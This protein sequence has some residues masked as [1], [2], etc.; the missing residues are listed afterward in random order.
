MTEPR[1]TVA[2]IIMLKTIEAVLDKDGRLSLLEKV[3]LGHARRVLITFLDDDTAG[4]NAPETALL[5]EGAL[6]EDWDKD[7]EEEAWQHL[8]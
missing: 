8:Q 3:E 1:Q 5:S 7:E 6:A 4:D 2:Y